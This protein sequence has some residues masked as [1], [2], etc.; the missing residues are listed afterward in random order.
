M[1]I[2]KQVKTI[3]TAASLV[4]MTGL[5]GFSSSAV[6]MTP[7]GETPAN[8][9]VCDDLMVGGITKGLYGLCVAYCEAQDLDLLGN[10]TP[11]SIRIL[12]NYDKK[13]QIGDPDMPC[14][15]A[16][17]P[18]WTDEELAAI[19]GT[20]GMKT[21]TLIDDFAQIENVVDTINGVAQR[22]RIDKERL[23]CRYLD[24]T[25]SPRISRR[26]GGI[27]LDEAEYCFI[28]VVEACSGI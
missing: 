15:K 1:D 27:L 16:P 23:L 25:V 26:T 9:G 28:K 20:G 2:F 13:K 3:I 4:L 10:K 14:I 19:L 17:C 6:A 11:P 24:R 5:A 21:C 18:C 7:D 22:A 8:E 12:Q